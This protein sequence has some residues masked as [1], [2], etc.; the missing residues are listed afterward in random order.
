MSESLLQLA[1]Q[2]EVEEVINKSYA[3]GLKTRLELLALDPKWTS[4]KEWITMFP[5]YRSNALGEKYQPLLSFSR[6]PAGPDEHFNNAIIVVVRL[7]NGYQSCYMTQAES[8]KTLSVVD[9]FKAAVDG[10]MDKIAQYHLTKQ[11][12][13]S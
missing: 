2:L 7:A 8:A 1:E 9:A 13:L 10:A 12:V 3:C 4:W 11:Y 5:E 6:P